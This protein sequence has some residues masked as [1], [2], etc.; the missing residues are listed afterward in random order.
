MTQKPFIQQTLI[1]P[2]DVLIIPVSQLAEDI[3][4]QL[5][6]SDSDYAITRPSSRIRS[7]VV[8]PEAA[9]FLNF[10]R[11]PTKMAQALLKYSQNN[12]LDPQAFLEQAFPLLKSLSNAG[13]LVEETAI[14][15]QGIC[16]SFKIGNQ[17]AYWEIVRVIQV[18]EDTEIY[19]V[20]DN[21]GNLAALKLLRPNAASIWQKAF[22]REIDIIRQLDG[23]V[24][25]Q[26]LD[27]NTLDNYR[28]FVMEWVNGQTSIDIAKNLQKA[29]NITARQKLLTLSCNILQAYAHLHQQQ[30]IH[31]DV[32]PKNILVDADYSVKIVDYGFS[33]CIKA[34]QAE[35]KVPRGGIEYFYEPEYAQKRLEDGEKPQTTFLGE[36]YALGALIYHLLTGYHYLKFAIDKKEQL[37]Q[38]ITE[39][40]LSFIQQGITPFSEVETLLITALQ[41]DPSLRFLCVA[42]FATQL[43]G[44]SVN[45]STFAVVLDNT[46]EQQLQNFR[47]HFFEYLSPFSFEKQGKTLLSP[48]GSV[49]FGAA[50]IAYSF[51]RVACLEN[52]AEMLS[53]AD[54][55]SM[56]ALKAMQTEEGAYNAQMG[57]TLDSIGD[58]SLYHTISGVHCLRTLIAH[59]MNDLPSQWEA[60]EAFIQVTSKE[61]K[62]L[63]LSMGWAGVLVGCAIL[64][65]R[66]PKEVALQAHGD[67]IFQHILTKIDTDEAISKKSALRSADHK[68]I[69]YLGM[70]HGWV[71]ILYALLRW[72]QVRNMP[73]SPIIQTRLQELADC[74]EK[75]NEGLGLRWTRLN[76]LSYFSLGRDYMPSWCNGAAGYVFLWT[77]AHQL[78]KNDHYLD[79]A[80]K[81]AHNV[82]EDL[83]TTANLCCG[84]TGAAYALLNMYRYSGDRQWYDA[85]KTMTMRALQDQSPSQFP[86]YS[87]YKGKLGVALLS[88]DLIYPEL[89]AMPLLESEG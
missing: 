50:G 37:R 32:H 72:C 35:I 77:L 82:R 14:D 88:F 39:K 46:F 53:Q 5:N 58:I 55:W 29:N 34:E 11:Q 26:L 65:E 68:T 74:A 60:T 87:L 80:L 23:K 36:Q 45:E 4:H 47:Q 18:L 24:N 21:T 6:C 54:I 25:P 22:E 1:L 28:Y 89:S 8:A 59:A 52:S 86:E 49:I 67:Q 84:F 40:P 62:H 69:K 51:Y 27:E 66:M 63:D 83:G 31:G 56:N 30:I 43:M 3:R 2:E 75:A 10:F 70:A 13:W 48:S 76:P 44:V 61:S 38:I 64:C 15:A 20:K 79:L 12:Q 33:R 57:L 81:T 17:I 19:Q 41:K 78:L 71:G 16:A 42:E 85:A 7:K 73:I 9:E